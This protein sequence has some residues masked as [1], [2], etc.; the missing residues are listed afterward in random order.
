MLSY[1]ESGDRMICS[2]EQLKKRYSDGEVLDFLFF[3]SDSPFTLSRDED[4]T[5]TPVH[6]NCLGQFYNSFF[7]ADGIR[8]FS[9]RGYIFYRKAVTVVNMKFSPYEIMLSGTPLSKNIMTGRISESGMV[10]WENRKYDA[11]VMG[12]IA[13]FS[14]NPELK[15]YLLG[16][17]S[18]IL[19]DANPDDSEWGIGIDETY[20]ELE[21]PYCWKGKNL[22]GFAL[23]E[24]RN[25]L[26]RSR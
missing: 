18:R 3:R 5:Y 11:A 21:N 25:R 15:E 22:L 17:G 6:R 4:G 24:V 23:M 2:I 7:R 1:R 19:V 13:K 8:F 9:L 12:N 26:I 20:S 10:S 14:Q 16:T